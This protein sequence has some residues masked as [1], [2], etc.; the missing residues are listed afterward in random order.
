MPGAAKWRIEPIADDANS[1]CTRVQQFGSI[2]GHR[3]MLRRRWKS[4]HSLQVCRS[5]NSDRPRCGL[6]CH[7]AAQSVCQDYWRKRAFVGGTGPAS[8]VRQVRATM[9]LW[10]RPVRD[11]GRA[12][13]W[14]CGMLRAQPRTGRYSLSACASVVGLGPGSAES[15]ID[16]MRVTRSRLCH[17]PAAVSV[18]RRP[19]C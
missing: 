13:W 18:H 19:T 10:R 15:R 16:T 2:R 11:G 5:C 12:S 9:L 4:C 6:Y 8:N 3:S 17:G 7:P 14:D 1:C